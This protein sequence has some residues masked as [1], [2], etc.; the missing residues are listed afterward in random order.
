[1]NGGEKWYVQVASFKD[2]NRAQRLVDQIKARNI[3]KEVHIIPTGN[4]FAVRLP[5]QVDQNIAQQQKQRLRRE[6]KVRPKVTKIK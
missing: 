2:K 5:P 6:L 4:W 1:A 3:S